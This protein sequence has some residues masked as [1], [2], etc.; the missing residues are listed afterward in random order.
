[1]AFDSM[2]LEAKQAVAKL[3]VELSARG[4]M[5]AT[6]GNL[7]VRVEGTTDFCITPSG[8]DKGALQGTDVLLLSL[9]GV[10][11]DESPYRPSAE[12]VV[13]QKLYASQECGSVVHVHT[14]YNNI[15]SQLYFHQGYVEFGDHELLKALG[16]WD[17]NARISVPIVENHADLPLLG[18]A[19]DEAVVPGVP[20]VLVRNHGIYAFGKTPFDAKKHLEAFEF[21]FEYHVRMLQLGQV[22]LHR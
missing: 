2:V 4:L 14:M 3:A 13:H 11:L 15:L 19:V 17:P 18:E 8:V 10:V 9:D 12:T 20:G 16:H 6:S 7:S 5:P 1:M 21:L 22:S